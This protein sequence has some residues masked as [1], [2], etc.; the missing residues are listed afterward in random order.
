MKLKNAALIVASGRGS[1]IGGS[2]PKQYQHIGGAPILA[3]TLKRF[4]EHDKIDGIIVVIHPDD[5]DL[6]EAVVAEL[7]QSKILPH[8]FGGTERQY[9]VTHG[10]KAISHLQPQNI[11]IH[12]G[13]RPFVEA[14]LID[15]L[16]STCDEYL[17]AIAA[18]PITDT[19]KTV[20]VKGAQTIDK[21]LDRDLLWAAQTPQAFDFNTIMKA[22][23]QVSQM[24]EDKLFTDDAAIFEHLDIAVKLVKS[25]ADNMKITNPED[26]KQAEARLKI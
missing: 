9:S 8:T 17:G 4:I 20:S 18:V 7:D 14:S 11:L 24:G 23:A 12:D 26:F 3:H 25:S 1:R 13:A 15:E 22:H 2:V 5:V 10:L 21:T 19:I 16:I 6:Y